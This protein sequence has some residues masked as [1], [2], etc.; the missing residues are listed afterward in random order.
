MGDENQRGVSG[1][2][3]KRVN[4]GIELVS[5]PLV[6]LLDEPTSGLD[7]TASADLISNLKSFAKKGVTVCMVIHQ[8]RAEILD[9]IDDIIVLREGG[10]LVY[11]GPTSN[12]LN[13]FE[14]YGYKRPSRTSPADFILDVT[15]QIK[16][17][18]RSWKKYRSDEIRRRK[19]RRDKVTP[20]IEAPESK[21]EVENDIE[22]AKLD[23]DTGDIS[24]DEEDWWPDKNDIAMSEIPARSRP[25]M[26]TQYFAIV[27][28]GLIQHAWRRPWVLLT[29]ATNLLVAGGLL[30]AVFSSQ[31][32]Q[33]I[34]MRYL[35]ACLAL[36]L[37]GMSMAMRVFGNERV[38]FWRESSAGVSVTAYFFGKITSFL[39]PMFA[40]PAFFLIFF[41]NMTN[42]RFGF[43]TYYI[44]FL[45]TNYTVTTMGYL[46]SILFEPKS[47][48][49]V[50]VIVNVMALL[51]AGVNPNVQTMAA[52][53]FGD[54]GMDLSYARWAVELQ[55]L[56]ELRNYP[57]AAYK[58][59]VIQDWLSLMGYYEEGKKSTADEIYESVP[60]DKTWYTIESAICVGHLVLIGIG[61]TLVSYL[62]I[63][64]QARNNIV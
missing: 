58:L 28:R 23:I 3:R 48:L 46:V 51:F 50:S 43:F 22:P 8:P 19:R 12:A 62:L 34:T 41:Y 36:G 60:F 1:G 38:Q 13:F 52:T 54:I 10:R 61:C 9:M 47:A 5:E 25:A 37:T 29:D 59:G 24:T 63:L 32:P 39:V 18:P 33:D 26:Y 4:I 17:L 56:Q 21:E 45:A 27:R 44:I 16:R 11:K 31:K 57:S 55:F 49:I 20:L 7:S 35:L 42:P 40:A 6:L 30:G 15:T 64:R 53:T 2:Q 14:K